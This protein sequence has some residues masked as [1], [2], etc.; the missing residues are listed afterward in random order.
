MM[1]AKVMMLMLFKQGPHLQCQ[2]DGDV[3]LHLIGRL[4]DR[5]CVLA[6]AVAELVLLKVQRN[7]LP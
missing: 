5:L 2:I 4:I 7:T 3:L 6:L 1:I